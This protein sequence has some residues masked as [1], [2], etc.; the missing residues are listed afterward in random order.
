[1]MQT[2]T[3]PSVSIPTSLLVSATYDSQKKVAVLKF[4]EP[5]S[6]KIILWADETGHKPYCYSKLDPE[7]L[8]FLS[9]RDDVIKI[10]QIIR[11]D[12]LKDSDI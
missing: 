8:G 10:E 7:D 5:K 9:D 11:H 4:Y 12:L 2:E 6:Q 3:K 1:M